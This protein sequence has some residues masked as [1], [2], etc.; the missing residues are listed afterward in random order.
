MQ[1][2]FSKL[3]SQTDIEVRFSVP[4]ESLDAFEFQQGE[5]KVN[6]EAIDIEEKPW[7]FRLTKRQKDVHPKPVL[8]A[9]WLAYVQD[10]R[11]QKND[12]LLLRVEGKETKKRRFRIHALRKAFRLFGED[13]WVDV[14]K[15]EEDNVKGVPSTKF[16]QLD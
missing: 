8:S 2:L 4:M 3:L 7:N 12:K 13:I 5:F 11:L 10:K 14:E 1:L 16:L 6:F 15:L 9:G